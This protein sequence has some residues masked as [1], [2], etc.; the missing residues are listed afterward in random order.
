MSDDEYEFCEIDGLIFS[1][2]PAQVR[3]ERPALLQINP[4]YESWQIEGVLNHE[5][6]EGQETRAGIREVVRG[7]QVLAEAL[8]AAYPERRF[9]IDNRLGCGVLSFFQAHPGA[10]LADDE[11]KEPLAEET[12]CHVCGKRQ[13]YHLRPQPDPEFPELEWA[14]CATCGT[15]L[16]LYCRSRLSVVGP[17]AR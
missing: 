9:M 7:A 1:I 11:P 13:R 12:Y 5:H 17:P 6:W 16:Y 8:R 2:S 3:N 14:D 10:P 15:E 4:A